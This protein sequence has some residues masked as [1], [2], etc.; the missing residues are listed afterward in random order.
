MHKRNVCNLE[1]RIAAPVMQH[2]HQIDHSLAVV[3]QL[4]VV[5]R[6]ASR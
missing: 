4:A 3:E 2:A 1:T 6:L 5:E